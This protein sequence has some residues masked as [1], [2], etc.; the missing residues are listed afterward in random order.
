[1]AA[2]LVSK[3]G[4]IFDITQTLLGL[5][6][7]PLFACMV[8]AVL[9]KPVKSIIMIF[10]IIAGVAAGGCVIALKFSSLWIA[11]VAF[12]VTFIISISGYFIFSKKNNNG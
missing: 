9:G 7:G 3:I 4:T 11:S 2:G 10:A 5:F 8:I 1:M 6:L 12:A